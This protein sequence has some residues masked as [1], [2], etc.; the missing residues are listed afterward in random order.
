MREVL[1]GKVNT[2]SF[3]LIPLLSESKIA[4]LCVSFTPYALCPVLD[5]YPALYSERPTPF[6]DISILRYG[7]SI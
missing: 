7:S 4:L 2:K 5:P 1:N 6:S 3:R